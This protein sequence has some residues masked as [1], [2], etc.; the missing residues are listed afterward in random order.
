M[1]QPLYFISTERL[2]KIEPEHHHWMEIFQV[3]QHRAFLAHSP[4]FHMF[5]FLCLIEEVV[6]SLT[7]NSYRHD[8]EKRISL[9]DQ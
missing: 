8:S 7:D 2:H 4:S 9:E 6:V 3:F 1:N 5:V